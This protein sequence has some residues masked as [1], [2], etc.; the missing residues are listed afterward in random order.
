MPFL[1]QVAAGA[2]HDRLEKLMKQRVQPGAN[3]DAIDRRIWDLFGEEWAVMFTDLSGFS[4]KV[5]EFGIIHFL[6]IIFES[7]QVFVPCIDRHD[8][9]LLKREGDSMLVIFRSVARA[10][11]CAMEMQR[12]AKAYNADKC[13]A[14]KVLLCVGLGFGRMLRIGDHD[15]F[16]AEVNAA[17]KLGEDTAKA[18]DILA[19]ESVKTAAQDLPGLSFEALPEAPPGA[20]AAYRIT[21]QL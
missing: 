10:I 21:Y 15:V 13:A 11:E 19:T 16:G 20:K 18:W 2:S 1:T 3:K 14:E 4:R 12:A 8:G 7:E 6:Q 17:S 9:I 5:A